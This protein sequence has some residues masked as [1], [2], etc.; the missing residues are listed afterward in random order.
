[1]C[2]TKGIYGTSYMLHIVSTYTMLTYILYNLQGNK[3]SRRDEAE[4]R[5]ERG[6]FAC[7]MSSA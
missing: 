6:Q 1:M 4:S 7:A 3:C 5:K 2:F